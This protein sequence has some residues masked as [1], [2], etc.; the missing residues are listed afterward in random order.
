LELL[1]GKFHQGETIRVDAHEGKLAFP[2]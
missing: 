2:K 1:E